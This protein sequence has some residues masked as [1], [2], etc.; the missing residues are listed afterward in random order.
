M[1]QA[2]GSEVQT[3]L[4][5]AIVGMGGF[6]GHH[7]EQ[8]LNHDAGQSLEL[9]AAIDPD[10]SG[11]AHLAALAERGTPIY[12]SID[13]YAAGP[14]ADLV[15]VSTPIH[16]HREHT[17]KVLQHGSHVYCEKPVA[18]TIQDAHAMA[19]ARDASGRRV[20]IGFQWSYSDAIQQLK[21]DIL[22]GDLGRPLRFR[23]LVCW[24]RD[25]TYYGR[26]NW[27]GQL[28][29]PDGAWI[30]DSPVSNAT[31]HYLHNCFYLLG[32]A[33][34][35][36]AFPMDVQAELYR[37]NDISNY[38]TAALRV[39]T[40]SGVEILHYAS[41]AV[42]SGIGP[43]MTYE[44]EN[45]TVTFDR[46]AE[47][48]FVARFNDGTHRD[49][50]TPDVNQASSLSMV[51]AAIRNDHPFACEIE[52]GL[53]LTLTA[54]LAQE[55]AGEIVDFPRDM[56]EADALVAVRQLEFILAECCTDACLP[57]ETPDLDWA[58]AGSI[59]RARGYDTFRG[60][61]AGG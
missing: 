45:A 10:P 46:D 59:V 43:V 2:A 37:A 35:T 3:P 44:F 42:T 13:A 31:S 8:I 1:K 6:A 4:T 25:A 53:P 61:A 22:A 21:A 27:A 34:H 54:N 49:Y 56:V 20:A 47:P 26:N 5:T 55:S 60:P 48:R 33:L 12:D 32:D 50:G 19:K 17:V 24:P 58:V 18:A 51:A 16:L 29:T 36:S 11:C 28:R 23:T 41:H 57:S 40:E 14:P 39:H 52:A 9:A 15:I 7:L 38:D 30:L